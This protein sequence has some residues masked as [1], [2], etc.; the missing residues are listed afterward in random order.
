MDNLF[1]LLPPSQPSLSPFSPLFFLSVSYF[2]YLNASLHQDVNFSEAKNFHLPGIWLYSQ[3]NSL[4][5]GMPATNYVE[6]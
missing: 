3:K 6:G 4:A 5:G 2:F 1:K